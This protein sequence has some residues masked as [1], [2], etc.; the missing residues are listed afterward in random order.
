[1]TINFTKH[2]PMRMGRAWLGIAFANGLAAAALLAVFLW[3]SSARPA[4]AEPAGAA[5]AAP[6]GP[7]APANLGV[8]MD[9]WLSTGT[10][11]NSLAYNGSI[12]TYTLRVTNHTSTSV[13]NI[14]I[15]DQLPPD[16]LS[17]IHCLPACD[18]IFDSQL[19]PEPLGGTLLVTVTRML[20]WSVPSL[21]PGQAVQMA[22]QAR[23]V[24]QADGTVFA[25]TAFA[26][27]N[28]GTG[29]AT[30]PNDVTATVRIN[31]GQTG[32]SG[33]ATAASWFST[34]VVG[35]LS[36]D[37][38]DFDRDGYLDLALGSSIGTA[39]YRNENGRL[40]KLDGW[41]NSNRTYGVRWADF[42]GNGQLELV[43]VGDSLDGTAVSAGVNYIY[44]RDGGSFSLLGTF[45]S[46]FQLVR[47]AVGDFDGD[48]HVDIVA[49]T[50]TI[51]ADCPVRL[52]R[53]DG[54]GGFEGPGDCVS[55]SATAAIGAGDFNND[56]KLDLALGLFPNTLQIFKNDGHGNF[57]PD[58]V[59]DDALPF[60]PY[61]LAW[62]NYNGSSFLD[63]AAA[64]PLQKEARI[65][66]NLG[67]T[68][69]DQPLEPF[70]TSLFMSPLAV[71]WGDFNGDGRLDLAVA[72]EAP[73]VYLNTGSGF[74]ANSYLAA[75]VLSGQV[76]SIRATQMEF[77]GSPQLALTNR[78]RPSLLFE[79]FS[80]RLATRL[81]Q[82]DNLPASSVAWGDANAN[83]RLDLLFGAGPAPQTDSRLYYNTQGTFGSSAMASVSAGPGPHN[84][85]FG[86]LI[87]NGRLEIAFGTAV[88]NRI[89]RPNLPNFDPYWSTT[90]PN[91]AVHKLAWGD[92]NSNGRL[93]LLVGAGGGGVHL[94][95]NMGTQLDTTPAFVTPATGDV[96][97]L[98]WAD[99]NKDHY[100]DFAVAFHNQPVRLYRNNKN[101]TFTEVWNSGTSL[102]TTSLAWGDF[103]ANGYLDLAVGYLG[104]S[105]HVYENVNGTLGTS[106][107]WSSPTQRNTTALAWGDWDNDGGLDLAIGN[108]NQPDQVYANLG[109]TPGQPRLFWLW[110]SQEA[111][112]T[113]GLAWG[114]FDGDGD[115]DL[116][117]SQNGSGFNGY[118]VNGTN[119][120]SHLT[121]N[122]I[123]TLGLPNNPSYVSVK[124]PGT[125]DGAYLYSSGQILGWGNGGSNLVPIH[126]TVYDPDGTRQVLGSNLA[127]DK[128]V[129]T[130]FEY[131]LDG[132]ST[133]H[134]AT[135]AGNSPAPITTTKRLGEGGLFIWDAGHDKA[136][137]DDARFRVRI[138]PE[139]AVGPVQR[140]SNT[141]ISP[142]FRIR[143]TSC[144]WPQGPSFS[145]IPSTLQPGSA[146]TFVGSI[147]SGTG[148]MTYTWDFGDGTP[149]VNGQVVAH[150]FQSNN[151][152]TVTMTVQGQ[153]CPVTRPLLLSKPI[154][155][156][157]GVPDAKLYLPLVMREPASSAGS[158]SSATNAAEAALEAAITAR[159]AAAGRAS[160]SGTLAAAEAASAAASRSEIVTPASEP[161]Q[162]GPAPAAGLLAAASEYRAGTA[163]FQLPVALSAADFFGPNPVPPTDITNSPVGINN[164][165]AFNRDGMRLAFWSTADLVNN[166][167]D[168]NIELFVA[169]MDDSGGI[170][171][172][173]VTSSTG[174]ILGGFN[175]SPSM[176]DSG[177]RVVFFSDR[178]LSGH[179][180]DN[181]F[182]IFLYD[183]TSPITLRQV[184][185]STKGFSILP[186]LSGNGQWVAFASDGNFTKQNPDG[187]T[188]IFRAHLAPNGTVTFMQVTNTPGGIN[189][190]PKINYDGTRIAFVSTFNYTGQ[191]ADN[192]RE[193]FVAA[194][195]PGGAV[196]IT[197]VTNTSS[198]TTG[199]P[200]IDASG[201]RVAFVSDRDPTGGNGNPGQ[202]RE[203][204]YADLG[205]GGA[206]TITQVPDIWAEGGSEKP[207]ISADGTRIGF[208]TPRH[209]QVRMYDIVAGQEVS[210]SISHPGLNPFLNA[211]GTAM[212]FSS[213][214]QLYVTHYPRVELTVTKAAKTPPIFPDD[215]LTY[216]LVVSNA[217]PSTALNVR[218]TDTLPLSGTQGTAS[219]VWGEVSSS[220]G[221]CSENPL[222][223][224]R[225]VCELDSLRA[226]QTATITVVITPVAYG[227]LDNHV[228]VS[229]DVYERDT[230]NG[231]IN[232]VMVVPIG[233]TGITVEGAVEGMAHASELYT[234]SVQPPNTSRPI[235]YTWQ[236]TDQP[237]VVQ[238]LTTITSTRVFTWTMGGAKTITVTATNPGQDTVTA[239]HVIKVN[240]PAP[241]LEAIAPITA[242]VHGPALTLNLTGTDFVASSQVRWQGVD[243]GTTGYVSSTRLTAT[244][245]ANRLTSAGTLTVSVFNP[246]PIGGLS[247]ALDFTVV[248]SRPVLTM[249]SPNSLLAGGPAFVLT[250]TAADTVPGAV[251]Y[252]GDK[253]PLPLTISS[254]NV[255]TTIV[256]ASYI[257][258]AGGV[259]VTVTNPMPN[260][261][262]SAA[263][264]VSVNN[265]VI[266]LAPAVQS[267]PLNASGMLTVSLNG[268]QAQDT[269]V[270]LTVTNAS[271]LQVPASVNLPAGQTTRTFSITS[272]ALGGVVTVTAQLPPNLGSGTATAQVTVSNPQPALTAI[273]PITATAGGPTFTLALTGSNFV[274]GVVVHFG[275]HPALPASL[276]SG[277][278]LTAS[279]P[280]SYIGQPGSVNITVTNP[281]PN[282]GASSAI[283][284]TVT[285]A[286]L[287]L[288]P[289][290]A[291]I[292]LGDSIRMTATLSAV[293][294]ED[295]EIFL[296]T[297]RP[298]QIV[299]PPSVTLPVGSTQVGFDV[300]TQGQGVTATITATLPVIVQVPATATLTVNNLRPV[301]TQLDPTL[302]EVGDANFHLTIT[303]TNLVPSSVVH[304]NGAALAG[305]VVV[306]G[307][308][309]LSVHVPPARFPVAGTY[310]V[311]V[312]N[313]APPAGG[314]ESDDS[315]T[316]TVVHPRP[317]ITSMN[318][319]TRL[320]GS[321]SFTLVITGSRFITDHTHA[322]WDNTQLA[323]TVVS[324]TRLTATVPASLLESPGVFSVTL[325][326]DG[327]GGG[328]AQNVLTF[329]VETLG[330]V[331]ASINPNTIEAGSGSFTLVVN[332][333]R[334]VNPPGTPHDSVILW[335]GTALPSTFFVSANQLT[336]T[337]PAANVSQ[338]GVFTVAVLN[339]GQGGSPNQLSNSV[340]FTVTNPLPRLTAITPTLATA[341][342][343]GIVL[344]ADGAGFING[345]SRIHYAGSL[346]T[347]TFIS[348]TRLQAGLITSD[349]AIPGTYTVTVVTDGPGGGTSGELDFV[350]QNVAPALLEV[351]P[352]VANLPQAGGLSFSLTVTGTNFVPG[353]WIA[354]GGKALPV[355]HFESSTLLTGTVPVTMVTVGGYYSVTVVNPPPPSGGLTATSVLTVTVFNPVPKLN[356][357][358]PPE[359]LA[360]TGSFSLAVTA[361]NLLNSIMPGAQVLW[362]GA[363]RATIVHT[364][365]QRLTATVLASDLLTWTAN[366][367]IRVI[368]PE[369]NQGPSDAIAFAIV[370]V[371]LTLEPAPNLSLNLSQSGIMTA[372]VS[373]AQASSRVIS[374]TSSAP[375][376]ASVPPSATLAAGNT[377]VTFTV[378]SLQTGTAQITANLPAGLS[379]GPSN[380]VEVTV[381]DAPTPML[382]HGT[383]PPAANTRRDRSWAAA[384][385]EQV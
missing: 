63:L 72:D 125:T 327:P 179:N 357:L 343:V 154:V 257:E 172:T 17:D 171:F 312:F 291:T 197:Q 24:G 295:R 178:N 43:A 377:F 14:Q 358:D 140:A 339:P 180:P 269:I 366:L 236:A 308:T 279:V 204:F 220:Q 45:M 336:A 271:V 316:V 237:T 353:A 22:F 192:N 195:G 155:I 79:A 351:S 235:T 126:Y 28:N 283:P 227:K 117:V 12:I 258:L 138:V 93:D 209:L 83:G 362:N 132:G 384:L 376:V 221:T 210:S 256:P 156:G 55:Q 263:L 297:N 371:E 175:L 39:I 54:S 231:L 21:A 11:D 88:A 149:L 70:R 288:T 249:L 285:A 355:T 1:M 34:D 242:I 62:G 278:Q 261:G 326:T 203:V 333:E 253:P 124:R 207:T 344:A 251:L 304:W 131:S 325:T 6:A 60:L 320:V 181:N 3:L 265:P 284:F 282:D 189:D 332:G 349:T 378:S 130:F 211:D 266:T 129:T 311:T 31:I 104:H 337:V 145:M 329:T 169:E 122:F 225:I 245:P 318:P 330:P 97:A 109:S 50:N 80:A 298:G 244:V 259:Q 372:S 111:Y 223:G 303:G 224:R 137:S 185:S 361:D 64:F 273:S 184:T 61:D 94:Y 46:E 160:A 96:R 317:V 268:V 293:Q 321:S 98:A 41:N 87:G 286:T 165:P 367:P 380:S 230:N 47:V 176:D 354:W 37:W 193:V 219:W 368:N 319:I 276:V 348:S 208:H 16:T 365:S 66:R 173:Q 248:Y 217:G 364:P 170:S 78:D 350:V 20:S 306:T 246:E 128:L 114:D 277:T 158:A 334:F 239:T 5:G 147:L 370:P 136:V 143:A 194:I 323:S 260:N 133:W 324:S 23:L 65:Y 59:V 40:V 346:R 369:P 340:L 73:R 166:N 281:A 134:K 153:P 123:N 198:G 228:T 101:N 191:N 335:N 90:A 29:F 105:V 212:A 238:S 26:T 38:G 187:N 107:A 250:V 163:L 164:E 352:E 174:S 112:A 186:D 151:T 274:G 67:G 314:L 345:A 74:N 82:V 275:S 68:S 299:L 53:N 252:W 148:A 289:A 177:N 218:L 106:P 322:L 162:G 48:G 75:D 241:V 95:L 309:E 99:F 214:R 115:L 84:V 100:M 374:L 347:T 89:Y 190:Q 294:A 118:Y 13:S 232:T 25:N 49:S 233:L 7:S 363:P 69:F 341:G 301:I 188:E 290:N 121:S 379:D 216:T 183:V 168:G 144:V 15:F 161:W 146:A 255:L 142:P 305:P 267:L 315:L 4:S 113:T 150:T 52:F 58:V 18:H 262:P 205:L 42:T 120:P 381:E 300:N 287:T 159:P 338:A 81:V 108:Q 280:A 32:Q 77:S 200:A 375:G 383:E 222:P 19:I 356:S 57:T 182:E 92:A 135:P 103:N 76:W 56:D 213:N 264:P 10:G 157:T 302:A 359:V 196:T 119:T 307:S 342:D 270:D 8:A 296:V 91:F 234:A 102:P 254:T 167:A 385:M 226:Y 215:P 328:L 27:Y 44:A 247:D 313:P 292:D 382:E 30:V 199:D 36:Q 272:T 85:A 310:T 373:A 33:M 139:V 331:I 51:N 141:A 152:Y 229:S 202:L 206:V 2:W 360:G 86:D 240:N 243:L 110:Q 116:A 71:D 35:T 201:T 127:G 9:K